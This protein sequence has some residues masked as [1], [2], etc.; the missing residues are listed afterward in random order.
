MLSRHSST[1]T[2]AKWQP[3]LR[4]CAISALS[5][6]LQQEW[7][8]DNKALLGGKKVKPYSVFKATWSCP[9]CPAGCPHIWKASVG[10][11]TVGTK[12]PYCEGRKLCKH[13]SLAT[14]HQDRS[15]SGI[16]T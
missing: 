9:K 5:L 16:R 12:C 8:P 4:Q 11:R 7:H 13:S 1:A 3:D 2:K 15:S 10:Q 6:Q 14:K